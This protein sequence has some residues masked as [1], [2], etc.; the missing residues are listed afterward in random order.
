[1][2]ANRSRYMTYWCEQLEMHAVDLVQKESNANNN[3]TVDEH[4]QM[5]S[6][7]LSQEQHRHNFERC[8]TKK[9]H[10]TS[11]PIWGDSVG[12][13]TFDKSCQTGVA[14]GDGQIKNTIHG[15][16]R[17]HRHPF[18]TAWAC[19]VWCFV[20]RFVEHEGLHHNHLHEFWSINFGSLFFQVSGF[21]LSC[22][23]LH[24]QFLYFLLQLIFAK[25]QRLCG[26]A[27]LQYF[28]GGLHLQAFFAMRW[29]QH[30]W[31][32]RNAQ[33]ACRVEAAN[34]RCTNKIATRDAMISSMTTVDVVGNYAHVN[35]GILL[36]LVLQRVAYAED[37]HFCRCRKLIRL[38]SICGWHPWAPV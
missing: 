36:V 5:I 32:H 4:R 2:L 34:N 22:F 24:G 27:L 12:R 35:D 13:C 29:I 30:F 37:V 11:L 33:D 6:P 31:R 38:R 26:L 3:N 17:V 21:P 1:M 20:W 25:L 9:K 15:C 10:Y 28:G 8:V 7:F 18:L 19:A 14:A 16:L 23:A